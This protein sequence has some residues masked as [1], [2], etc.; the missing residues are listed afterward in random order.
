MQRKHKIGSLINWILSL[1]NEVHLEK[2]SYKSW[3]KNYG[4][5]VQKHAPGQFVERL[6]RKAENAG[7]KALEINPYLGKLSQTCICGKVEKKKLS[8]RTHECSCGVKAQRDLFS[9]FLAFH[10][11]NNLLDRGQ[12]LKA[13][14][15]ARS[16]LEQALSEWEQIARIG[17]SDRFERRQS[18]SPVKDGSTCI[19]VSD[20]VGY[21]LPR[22]EKRYMDTAVR[23]PWL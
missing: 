21:P 16:L 22:A 8:Q 1:G 23:T 18:G 5:S 2:L 7:G 3:Q 4:R 20:V 6:K 10:T 14:P 19:E 11:K 9:A 13:W 12:A 15:G 17:S